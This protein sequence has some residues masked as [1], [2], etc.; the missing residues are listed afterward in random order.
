MTRSSNANCNPDGT[1]I[2]N[3]SFLQPGGATFAMF[4]LMSRTRYDTQIFSQYTR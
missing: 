3:M 2:T 4:Q 1:Y